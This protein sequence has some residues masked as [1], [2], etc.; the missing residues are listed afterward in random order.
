M[1]RRSYHHG[2]LR[3]AVLL[4]AERIVADEGE[5]SVTVRAVARALGVTH[6][7][8]HHHYPTRLALLADV[9][10]VGYGKLG[11]F[12][13][14]SA[15]SQRGALEALQA[16]GVG[17]VVF[18]FEN[19][20]LFRLMFSGDLAAF[21]EDSALALAAADAFSVFSNAL[22]TAFPQRLDPELNATAAWALVHGLSVLILDQ[23]IPHQPG[24]RAEV[25]RLV[26]AVLDQ[27]RMGGHV[28]TTPR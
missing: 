18:A 16:I 9:A 7:A 14:A 6:T 2:D 22:D 3:E 10:S 8:V 17:Y 4:E 25:E 11:A 28:R 27:V 20:G 15:A 24:S 1:T 12:L 5:S 19:P 23:Q 21:R 13:A 26:R